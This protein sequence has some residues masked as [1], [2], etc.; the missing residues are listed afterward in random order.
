MRRRQDVHV[1]RD[2]IS[3][4]RGLGASRDW[5]MPSNLSSS[6]TLSGRRWRISTY[7]PAWILWTIFPGIGG[8]ADANT[9]G[10]ET[11]PLAEVAGVVQPA[12][13]IAA[14]G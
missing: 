8:I 9:N 11:L 1:C 3:L 7:S 4:S 5:G 12:V 6:V 14:A 13:A 10:S 2:V